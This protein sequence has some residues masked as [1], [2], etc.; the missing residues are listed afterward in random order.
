MKK[1]LY[2]TMLLG[3]FS[4]NQEYDDTLRGQ[5]KMV[6]ETRAG[7]T[8]RVDTLFYSFDSRI[9]MIWNIRRGGEVQT[10]FTQQ[11]DS[12]QI[13]FVYSRFLET[14]LKDTTLYGWPYCTL[15]PQKPAPAMAD[16]TVYGESLSQRT[17]RILEISR[18]R[19][20]L[21]DVYSEMRFKRW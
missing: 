13:A 5:W 2:I 4:C 20:V 16:T 6:E 18:T 1:I 7:H 15:K 11:G 19:L 10:L 17:F 9:C 3:L 14:A 12:L 21:R 8:Y